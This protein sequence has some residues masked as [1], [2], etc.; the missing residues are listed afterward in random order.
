MNRPPA[1]TAGAS[2]NY[3]LH[4]RVILG[5]SAR[6]VRDQLQYGSSVDWTVANNTSLYANLYQTREHGTGMD[7]QGSTP[8]A[9]PTWCSAITAAGSTPAT[10]MKPCPTAPPAAQYLCRPDQQFGLSVNHRVDA[11]NSWNLRLS[12]SEGNAEGAGLDLGWSRR[13]ILWGSD[14][15][16]RFSVFDRPG[17]PAPTTNATVAWTCP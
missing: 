15:N 17:S 5:L 8:L 10:P 14:A 16:W 11:R 1:I 7:L 4:P 3:L 12:H 2:V 9:P 6:E 13:D